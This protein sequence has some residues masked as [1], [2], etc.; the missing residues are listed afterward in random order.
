MAKFSVDK[1]PA[2]F[3]DVTQDIS[4]TLPVDIIERW[5]R[6]VQSADSARKLLEPNRIEGIVVSSDSAGLTRLTERLGV[7]EIL[8]LI[9][10]PKQ[11]LH[12]YG[13]ALGGEAVGI[14]A[15]D[16]TEMFYPV[17]TR[18]GDVVSM[19]LT[20]QDQIGKECRVQ[21]GL[22]AHHGHFFRLG[23]GLYGADAERV[24]SVSEDHTEG[25]EI[26]ITA[27]L[28]S[29]LAC[30]DNFSLLPRSDLPPEL[31]A[32]LRVTAG[33]RRDDLTPGD[34]RYPIPY[35]EAFYADLLRYAGSPEDL[36]LLKEV[37]QTYSRRRAVVL[38]ERERDETDSVEAAVLNELALSL[39]MRKI[40]VKLLGD[41]GGSEIKTSGSIGIYTFE[42]CAAAL[43]F[44]KRFRQ[45]FLQQGIDSRI[46]IDY[47]EVLVFQVEDGIEDI[48][49]AP[50]NIASKIAQDE[51]VFG[52]IYISEEAARS[53]CAG[54]EFRPV[55][56]EVSGVRI[57]ALMD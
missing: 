7:L 26:V 21:V 12:A 57:C 36:Q 20:A 13:A 2:G 8:A 6:G 42:D 29:Q 27:E 55:T 25:G 46:A 54:S 38:I 15:A 43:A 3:F 32:N 39:A 18:A 30:P 37:H 5:T 1:F 51:G 33:P 22:A 14:W 45:G 47:G 17:D 31:G 10:R 53:A 52:K 28:A 50:V 9:D 49:G 40:G 41:H 4:R 24:E 11:L 48:A 56:F 19:L 35:S 34:V 44:A 23:G 16:N